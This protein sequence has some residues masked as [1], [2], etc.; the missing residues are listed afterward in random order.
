MRKCTW[1][2]FECGV[3]VPRGRLCHWVLLVKLKKIK[4][5]AKNIETVGIRN[6]AGKFHFRFQFLHKF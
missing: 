3:G 1:A 6:C 2:W 4:Y 5:V